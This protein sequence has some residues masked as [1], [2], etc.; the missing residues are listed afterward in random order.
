MSNELKAKMTSLGLITVTFLR[1][2]KIKK[3][4]RGTET[5]QN[6]RLKETTVPEKAVKPYGLSHYGR[7]D[8]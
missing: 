3:C 1:L 8:T 5:V 7:Y 4:R 6:R 2:K